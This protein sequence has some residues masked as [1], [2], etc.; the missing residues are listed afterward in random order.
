[1]G[2]NHSK[3]EASVQTSPAAERNTDFAEQVCKHKLKE[4][5]VDALSSFMSSAHLHWRDLGRNLGFKH[6]DLSNIVS[7]PAL[8]TQNDYFVEMLNY[9]LKW[10]PPTKPQPSTEDLIT[11]LRAVGEHN[12]ALKLQ[13]D[14]A[15]FMEEK[16]LH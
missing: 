1:M 8:T 12:L 16:R 14:R 10:A 13:E 3:P 9:Y 2:K 4:S 11:A 7:K 6:A 5:D 15:N